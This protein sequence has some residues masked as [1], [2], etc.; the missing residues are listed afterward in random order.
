MKNNLT[1]QVIEMKKLEML[2]V[3]GIL[4]PPPSAVI[5]KV[6][7]NYDLVYRFRFSRNIFHNLILN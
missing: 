1:K 5:K 6:Q 2:T 7:I 4:K 3:A